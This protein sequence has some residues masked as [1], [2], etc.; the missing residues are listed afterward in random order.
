[1]LQLPPHTRRDFICILIAGAL[2]MC[3]VSSTL[4][5]PRYLSHLGA[6]PQEIGWLIGVP[7]P[8]YVVCTL[9]CGWL[10]DRVSVR[11]LG[12]AGIM[13]S[14]GSTWAM[15]LQDSVTT[16]AWVLRAIQGA[17]HAFALTPIVTMASRLLDVRTRAQGLGYFTVCMQMGNVV[18]TLLASIL[19][20]AIGFGAYFN[21]ALILAVAGAMAFYTVG[22]TAA[23]PVRAMSGPAA[24]GDGKGRIIHGLALM[25][26]LGG[27]FGMVLQYSPLMLDHLVATGQLNAPFSASWILTTLLAALITVRLLLPQAIYRSGGEP[28]LMLCMAGIPAA[29]LLFPAIRGLLGAVAVASLLGI[30]YGILL[31]M[32]QALCLNRAGPARQGWAVSLTNLTFESGYRGF[33]FLMGP[34]VAAFG[35]S[36]MFAALALLTVAGTMIFLMLEPNRWRWLGSTP[37]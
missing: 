21:A 10:A 35:Y 26:V 32:V 27:G 16:W 15:M 13:L 7:V 37:A 17:G 34:V 28:W 2:Y 18:G 25:L 3:S 29:L 11:W 12:L 5:L 4:L 24:V 1:M 20:E 9:L 19:I 14:A 30:C 6:T 8:F 31:P 36:G 22:D 33:G 23:M